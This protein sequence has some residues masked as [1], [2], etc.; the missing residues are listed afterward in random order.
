VARSSHLMWAP[1]DT[2]PRYMHIG[3]RN[4][5]ELK[6][7]LLERNAYRA[8]PRLFEVHRRPLR[9]ILE[10]AFSFSSYPWNVVLRTPVGDAKVCLHSAAD[11]STANLVF[12]RQDYHMPPRAKVVVDVGSNIGLSSVYW[13]T[14]HTESYVHCFEPAPVTYQR[15]LE[16]LLPYQGRFTANHVAVSDFDG[17]ASFGISPCGV[18]SSLDLPQHRAVGF[19]NVRVVHINGVLEGVIRQHGRIDVLK[20]DSEGHE[21][22]SL[23]AI[24]PEFWKRIRCVN[25]GCHDNA[26]AIPAGFKRSVV[27]SAERY[28]AAVWDPRQD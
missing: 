7:L 23:L 2:G 27:G 22:R 1:H 25:V 12:C 11:L 18:N 10:E 20:L 13:L 21:F 3:R 8:I 5:R 24:S 26:K 15:M 6:Q 19:V 16:N 28:C 17:V 14:R 9:V 4:L